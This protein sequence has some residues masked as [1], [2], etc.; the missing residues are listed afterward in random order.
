MDASEPRFW[1]AAFLAIPLAAIPMNCRL[2]AAR[3]QKSAPVWAAGGYLILL[4][5]I[6]LYGLLTSTRFGTAFAQ[7]A[8]CTFPG[9]ALVTD[10]L[11]MRGFGSLGDLA[12][13]YVRFV[14]FCGG[15]NA[16]LIAGC[17]WPDGAGG[18]SGGKNTRGRPAA[19][20]G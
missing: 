19:P 18:R 17:L 14:C 11:T 8:I 10:T 1:A 20:R 6:C 7:L 9:S 2:L 5:L 13:N 15:L 12:I 16:L 3:T 4:H